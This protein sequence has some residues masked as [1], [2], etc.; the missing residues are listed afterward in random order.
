MYVYYELIVFLYVSEFIL[1]FSTF[2]KFRSVVNYDVCHF[3][4]FLYFC[5]QYWS[6]YGQLLLYAYHV[7]LR[8]AYV[9]LVF[10]RKAAAKG[11]GYG[12]AFIFI[13]MLLY[14]F[15]M[16][17]YAF[18][19]VSSCFIYVSRCFMRFQVF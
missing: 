12:Y 7:K 19:C 2:A 17:V 4:V 9:K 15:Y 3:C 1:G 6:F 18:I 16:R 14:S 5:C 13:F 10:T 11:Q 8:K